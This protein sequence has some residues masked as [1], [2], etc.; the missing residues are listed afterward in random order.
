MTTRLQ[1]ENELSLNRFKKYHK[2]SK[3]FLVSLLI[4]LQLS[5]RAGI[6]TF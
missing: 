1:M 3:Q 5:I 4:P 6:L 2:I